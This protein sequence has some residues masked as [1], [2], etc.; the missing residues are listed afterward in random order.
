VTSEPY[1]YSHEDHIRE[2]ERA[3]MYIAQ[4]RRKAEEIAA[5]LAKEGAE[6]RLV[7]GLQTAA[8]ALRAEHNRLLNT[9]HFPVPD[10]ATGNDP[11]DAE[12]LGPLLD[13]EGD[14]EQAV[15]QG[16]LAI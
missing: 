4:A 7:T 2:V 6:E 8:A 3:L 13:T 14:D 15:D 9:S 12:T 10:D 11:A 1:D 16:R 5:A